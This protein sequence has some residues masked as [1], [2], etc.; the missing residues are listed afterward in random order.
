MKKPLPPRRRG[1]RRAGP[2][3]VEVGQRIRA[4]RLDRGMSQSD[5]ADQIDLTFQQVQ[6]Y[7]N[8]MNRVGAGRLQQIAEVLDVPPSF[9]F[10]DRKG[11]AQHHGKSESMFGALRSVRAMRMLKAFNRIQD[12]KIQASL[13][14]LAEHLADKA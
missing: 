7:E 4:R 14:T 11:G 5:L 1:K 12:R 8:G 2:W 10:R 13:V 9:F 3:D 6:K